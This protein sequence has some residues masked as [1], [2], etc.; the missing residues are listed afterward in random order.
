MDS[1]IIE[2]TA[3]GTEGVAVATSSS[4][5]AYSLRSHIHIVLCVQTQAVHQP[6]G[7]ALLGTP[8]GEGAARASTSGFLTAAAYAVA[9]VADAAALLADAA[10]S[11]RRFVTARCCHQRAN[12]QTSYFVRLIGFFP[13]TTVDKIVSCCVSSFVNCAFC[14][15]TDRFRWLSCN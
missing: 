11:A 1:F 7:S 6:P 8:P 15:P 10:A 2:V 12:R 4:L 3:E 14:C 5:H 13:G 9:L